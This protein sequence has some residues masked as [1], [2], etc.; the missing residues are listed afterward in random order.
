MEKIAALL[1]QSDFGKS[2]IAQEKLKRAPE[3]QEG[4]TKSYLENLTNTV[5]KSYYQQSYLRSLIKAE[6]S[7]P[8]AAVAEEDRQREE[9]IGILKILLTC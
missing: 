2:L 4:K 5:S 9:T 6:E 8:Q 1:A 3:Y 7:E